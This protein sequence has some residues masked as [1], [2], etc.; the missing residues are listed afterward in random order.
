[1]ELLLV[2]EERMDSHHV[3]MVASQERMIAKMDAWLAKMGTWR[4]EMTACQEVADAYLENEELP[5]LEI[6]SVVEHEKVPKEEAAVKPVGAL[7]RRQS[8]RHQAAGHHGKPKERTQGNGGSQMK[9]AAGCR[10]MTC[11]AGVITE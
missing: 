3:R 4:K 5:S 9:L 6:E 1:M 2:F 11:R 10:G 7:K 8:G